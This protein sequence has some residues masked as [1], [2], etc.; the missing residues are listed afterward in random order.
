MQ[1]LNEQP[2]LA[3][4]RKRPHLSYSAIRSYLMCPMKYWHNYQNK[5]EPSHRPL[6]LVLGSAVHQALAA[7]YTHCK[8]TG[9]KISPDELL[10]VFRDTID[11]EL[12]RPVPIKLPDDGDAGGMLDQGVAMLQV[13]WEKADVP[14]VIA[15]EQAFAVPLFDP[16][17]G[18]QFD[19]P[20]I[21][22]MDLLVRHKGKPLI[23][24]HKTSARRYAGWQLELEMQ[25]SVYKYAAEQLGFGDA[26][27]T[28]QILLKAKTPAIQH[29]KIKRTPAQIREMLETFSAIVKAIDAGHFW[30]NRSWACS[31]C[32]YA[33]LCD[34]DGA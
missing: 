16:T 5:S 17:T 22:A 10:D 24:E 9:M 1:A 25:P 32:Q 29:C 30:K 4:L 13:F 7:Y 15:V 2:S 14:E 33:W 23:I 28:Y 20:L 6:A 21:G 18:E 34:G 27:L 31:D 3:E 19:F 11:R 26:D 8:T 12:D